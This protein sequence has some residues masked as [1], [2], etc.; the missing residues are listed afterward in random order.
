MGD[1]NSCKLTTE[2][3][4]GSRLHPRDVHD[5]IE[6][7]EKCEIDDLKAVGTF[8]TWT[9]RSE[10]DGKILCKLDKCLTNKAWNSIFVNVE[11]HFLAHGVFDHSPVVLKWHNNEG[12]GHAPFRFFNHWVEH[13]DFK[14]IVEEVWDCNVL[15]NP[16]IRLYSKLKLLKGKLIEWSKKN[17]SDLQRQV[18]EAWENLVKIQESIQVHPMDTQL[19][20]LEKIALEEYIKLVASEESSLKQKAG[21]SNGED[22]SLWNDPWL[23]G[24]PVRKRIPTFVRHLSG[25][26]DNSKLSFVITNHEW[27]LPETDDQNLQALYEDIRRVHIDPLDVKDKL[28]WK[29]HPRGTYTIKTAYA[30]LRPR[31]P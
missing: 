29:P 1:F 10:G 16:M 13:P 11:A 27:N 30:V 4:G 12:D 31:S 2:K 24:V 6:G 21:V 28:C 20:T 17:F 3:I 18:M 23:N 25:H 26:R 7:M 8:Y 22:I 14:G 19:A 15:G 9:N 5:L